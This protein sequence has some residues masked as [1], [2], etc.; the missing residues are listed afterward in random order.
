MNGTDQRKRVD[1]ETLAKGLEGRWTAAVPAESGIVVRLDGKNFSTWTKRFDKPFDERIT[2][3]FIETTR[4][5]MD[6]YRCDVAYTQS[7]EISLVW[8]PR[9]A[10][11]QHQFG[12]KVHK[13]TSVIT[14]H[15]TVVFNRYFDEPYALFDGRAFGC[16]R[17]ECDQVLQ[18]RFRDAKINA[19][20]SIAQSMFSHRQL[21]RM[22]LRDRLALI[23]GAGV[24]IDSFPSKNL[25]GTSMVFELGSGPLP[26]ERLSS[27]PEEFRPAGDVVFKQI[28]ASP[29]LP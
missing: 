7:D 12:G 17:S 28:K 26:P 6:E 2:N 8:Y 4:A 9:E 3:A 11:S 27:I 23:E 16:S 19:I 29:G 15:C 5:L 20:S 1:F 18:W 14:S 21:D 22:S 25:L 24:A 10:T 13:L